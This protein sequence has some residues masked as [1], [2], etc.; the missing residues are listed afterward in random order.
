MLAS[1]FIALNSRQPAG[2][3]PGRQPGRRMRRKG[4][5]IIRSFIAN[6]SP[7]EMS[8]LHTQTTSSHITL[9]PPPHPPDLRTSASPSPL[10]S[11]HLTVRSTTHTRPCAA[12][13]KSCPLLPQ[14]SA[15]L[16]VQ[17]EEDL[18]LAQSA[19]SPARA[20]SSSVRQLLL[21]FVRFS[22]TSA[23]AAA[24]QALV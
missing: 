6:Q 22:V 12:D 4:L 11:L 8:S 1:F 21:S 23:G 17:F 16:E 3:Q 24:N 7:C 15:R 2:R 5:P 9:L 18:A 20:C 14:L 10:P 19:R 13:R